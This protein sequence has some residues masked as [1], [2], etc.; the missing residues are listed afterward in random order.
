[1][2][3]TKSFLVLTTKHIYVEPLG[4]KLITIYFWYAPGAM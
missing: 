3:A 2:P 4:S 1:M